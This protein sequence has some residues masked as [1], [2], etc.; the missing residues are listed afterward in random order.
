MFCQTMKPLF[1][2]KGLSKRT[3]TLIKGNKII[4]DDID[5]ANTLNSFFESAVK[6]TEPADFLVDVKNVSDPI[7]AAILKFKN[8]PSIKRIN[9]NVNVQGRIQGG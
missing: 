4:S 5:V 7:D 8:H 2:D 9:E 3:I 1:T 6:I